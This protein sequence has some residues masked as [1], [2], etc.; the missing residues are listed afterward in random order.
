MH[1]N[2]TLSGP[3][4][5]FFGLM[6]MVFTLVIILAV[7]ELMARMVLPPQRESPRWLVPDKTYGFAHRPSFT[8]LYQYNNS[9]VTW[10]ARLNRL[11][12]R[13]P[14]QDPAEAGDHHVLLLGDSFTFGYGLE[15]DHI[16]AAKLSRLLNEGTNRWLV[17]NAGVGGW[18]P[19]QS[20]KRALEHYDVYQPDVIVFTLCDN[21]A[22]DDTIFLSGKSGGLLPDF[23]GK[24]WV[25]DHVYLYSLLYRR[26]YP[27]MLQMAVRR[28]PEEPPAPPVATTAVPVEGRNEQEVEAA[29][30]LWGP[31]LKVVREFHQEFL[32]RNPRG[33]MLLQMAQPLREDLR[34]LFLELDNGRDLIFVD[35]K[36][37]TLRIGADHQLLPYDPHWTE[38]MHDLSAS[39][40]YHAI[41]ERWAGH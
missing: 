31:T 13:G 26:L 22:N 1:T 4:K 37:D 3:K 20:V 30:A 21:D 2:E 9:D 12:L 8:Q 34:T 40:L 17:L 19:R 41:K 10:T 7:G 29:R 11:A 39:N 5:I 14:E 38:E 36:A 16:F 23:K 35:F 33:L 6:L 15:D 27:M 25:K 28:G 32:R 24:R 18:G